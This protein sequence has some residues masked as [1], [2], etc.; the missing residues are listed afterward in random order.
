[1][2][3]APATPEPVKATPASSQS[4]A[5]EAPAQEKLPQTGNTNEEGAFLLGAL[6]LLGS[7][8]LAGL[9]MKRRKHEA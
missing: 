6:G 3:A 9:G 2:P 7:L 4:Q 5:K 8:S 1:T